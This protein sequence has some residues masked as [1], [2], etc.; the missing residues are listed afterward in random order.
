MALFGDQ[1]VELLFG[2]AAIFAGGFEIVIIVCGASE[3][4]AAVMH[5]TIEGS[6]P[7]RLMTVRVSYGGRAVRGAH[8]FKSLDC[9]GSSH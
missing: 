8:K 5:V 2:E 3:L 1:D 4:V 7:W 9:V 6:V